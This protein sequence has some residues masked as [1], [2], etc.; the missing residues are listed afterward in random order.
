VFQRFNGPPFLTQDQAGGIPFIDIADRYMANGATYDPRVLV[1]LTREQIAARLR[2][3]DNDQARGILGAANR[4]TATMCVATSNA[5]AEVCQ[6]P[7]IQQI[8]PT[9]PKQPTG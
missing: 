7:T 2:T 4:L 9:L 5:P 6:Q 3:A 1:G 8:E